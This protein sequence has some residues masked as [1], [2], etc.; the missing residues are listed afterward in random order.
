ME[1]IEAHYKDKIFMAE[2]GLKT[3]ASM[4][5]WPEN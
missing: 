2:T 3:T 5:V 1:Y 4:Y